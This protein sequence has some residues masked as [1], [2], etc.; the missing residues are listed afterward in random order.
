MSTLPPTG[1]APSAEFLR[2]PVSYLQFSDRENS[3]ERPADSVILPVCLPS[4][5]LPYPR[6]ASDAGPGFCP[7]KTG[8]H[9][10]QDSWVTVGLIALMRSPPGVR[11]ATRRANASR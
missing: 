10:D 4:T 9:A 1:T 3:A 11:F 6:A 2:Y 8:S 7:G 5:L